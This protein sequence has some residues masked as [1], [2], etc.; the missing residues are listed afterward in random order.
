MRSARHLHR[1]SRRAPIC[2]ASGATARRI[3]QHADTLC[4]LR[5]LGP[6]GITSTPPRPY[7]PRHASGLPRPA[8]RRPRVEVR[9]IWERSRQPPVSGFGRDHG[10]LRWSVL[11]RSWGHGNPDVRAG[12]R[13][14]H[15][16]DPDHHNGIADLRRL[17]MARRR[18]IRKD[19]R[20]SVRRGRSHRSE[21]C[22]HRRH[23]AGATECQGQRRVR[24]RLLH[25][26]TD[27]PHERRSQGGV[28]AA[29]PRPQDLGGVGQSV[30]RRE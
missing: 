27:R 23:P 10:G 29:E 15:H 5:S 24:L 7:N 17:F 3:R 9:W 8:H 13:C 1:C 6:A 2:I 26:E 20:Q 4:L 12:R 19:R 18:A 25:P 14:A 28:R 30:F 16:Q 22:R 21:E 11:L